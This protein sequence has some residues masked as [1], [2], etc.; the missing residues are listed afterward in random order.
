MARIIKENNS[1]CIRESC[2]ALNKGGIIIIPTVRWYMITTRADNEGG[3]SAIFAAK[4]RDRSRQPL[5]VV[6]RK[7]TI[8]SY[9]QVDEFSEKIIKRLMPGEITLRMLWLDPEKSRPFSV[10][11]DNALVYAA[12]GI[13]GRIAREIGFPLAA[14][15]PNV[16]SDDNMGPA[17]SVLEAKRFITGTKVPVDII[18]DGGLSV[19]SNNTTIVDSRNI[20]EKHLIERK[21]YVNSRVID[22]VQMD[23]I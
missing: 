15:T 4:D 10:N 17:L 14:T 3:V 9:F 7:E 6:P 22:R 5:F 21:G 23:N 16:S 8:K 12:S 18:I 11:H 19:V 20:G 1:N 13:F 2:N